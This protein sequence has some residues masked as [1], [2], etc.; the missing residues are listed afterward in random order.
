MTTANVPAAYD[1]RI[2]TF[3]QA[4]KEKMPLMKAVLPAQVTPTRVL[5]GWRPPAKPASTITGA[6]RPGYNQITWETW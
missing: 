4:F 1:S 3:R 5:A 6:R 2:K